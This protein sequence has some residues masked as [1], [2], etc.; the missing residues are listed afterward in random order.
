MTSQEQDA[1]QAKEQANDDPFY[2]DFQNFVTQQR[3]LIS[4]EQ[5]YASDQN[6]EEEKSISMYTT[7]KNI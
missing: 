6:T 5:M 2:E 7:P 4:Q 1:F 3:M